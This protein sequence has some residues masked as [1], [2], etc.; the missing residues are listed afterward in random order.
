MNEAPKDGRLILLFDE[1][2]YLGSWWND[3]N[4]PKE[5][6][7]WFDN[8]F[9]D[10]SCGYASTPLNPTHWMPLPDPPSQ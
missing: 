4:F 6:K 5:P 3:C 9:D 7:G 1:I 8:T 10:F 2:E